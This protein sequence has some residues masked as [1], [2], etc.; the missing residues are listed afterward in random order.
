MCNGRKEQR[1][2]TSSL[3]VELV[4]ATAGRPSAGPGGIGPSASSSPLPISGPVLLSNSEGVTWVWG[5]RLLG[6]AGHETG[7]RDEASDPAFPKPPAPRSPASLL[8]S[9]RPRY[10]VPPS[11]LRPYPRRSA[12]PQAPPPPVR[13]PPSP[14]DPAPP[15]RAPSPGPAYACTIAQAPGVAEAHTPGPTFWEKECTTPPG[16]TSK[17]TVVGSDTARAGLSATATR[18]SA[19]HK[20]TAPPPLFL[21]LLGA[22][23]LGSGSLGRGD[24]RSAARD[25]WGVRRRPRQRR[26]D[27]VIRSAPPLRPGPPS[28]GGAWKYREGT[29]GCVKLEQVPWFRVRSSLTRQG[30][31]PSVPT[32]R[33][34]TRSEVNKRPPII[35]RLI[36]VGRM[37][38]MTDHR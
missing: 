33:T 36:H 27:H 30:I 2:S 6:H 31:D 3:V 35:F 5:I 7:I 34:R 12:T 8:S 22:A 24:G 10:Q 26:H 25:K 1:L 20:L 38:E 32:V 19:A 28:W 37:R 23:I 14:P 21:L 9:V 11:I 4:R 13:F 18:S 15:V 16:R 29:G 17:A